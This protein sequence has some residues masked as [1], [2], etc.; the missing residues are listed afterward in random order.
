[1]IA[2]HI[3]CWKISQNNWKTKL[4]R[5]QLFNPRSTSTTNRISTKKARKI[6]A[7][8]YESLIINRIKNKSPTYTMA[9]VR[10]YVD[11][12]APWL[13][14]REV[15]VRDKKSGV[16]L[17]HLPSP[18]FHKRLQMRFQPQRSKQSINRALHL[19]LATLHQA[20]EVLNYACK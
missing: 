17:D 8:L 2:I 16:G 13:W 18:V 9:A 20:T 3:N 15:K 11:V 5:R 14:Y 1:M 12:E 7:S 10:P 19:Q 6:Y 4:V